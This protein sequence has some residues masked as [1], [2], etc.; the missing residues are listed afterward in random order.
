MSRR[1]GELSDSSIDAKWPH[2]VA[3]HTELVRGFHL[4]WLRLVPTVVWF[5]RRRTEVEGFVRSRLPLAEWRIDL[6]PALDAGL[7][8]HPAAGWHKAWRPPLS[9]L[10]SEAIALSLAFLRSMGDQFASCSDASR[11]TCAGPH[12]ARK[13]RS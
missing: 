1:K 8:A 7:R 4:S 9:A 3:V 10:K 11:D 12:S 6:E 13:Q 5:T 2:Q